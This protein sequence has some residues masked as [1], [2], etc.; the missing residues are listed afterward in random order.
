MAHPIAGNWAAVASAG[1]RINDGNLGRVPA[2]TYRPSAAT[3]AAL[4]RA[5]R[6]GAA[7]LPGVRTV[8]LGRGK[9]EAGPAAASPAG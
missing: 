6:A 4:D 8:R 1:I 2:G 5:L 3:L 9:P 7:L